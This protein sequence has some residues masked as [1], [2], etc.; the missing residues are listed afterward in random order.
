MKRKLVLLL[1]LTFVLPFPASAQLIMLLTKDNVYS[2]Y[3]WFSKR[4]FPAEEVTAHWNEGR[5]IYSMEYTSCGTT[6]AMAKGTGYGYQ[7]YKVSEPF[8]WPEEWVREQLNNKEHNMAISDVAYDARWMVVCTEGT[9]YINQQVH[10]FEDEYSLKKWLAGAQKSDRFITSIC[11]GNHKWRVVSSQ[12][13]PYRSQGVFEAFS[14][15]GVMSAINTKVWDQGLYVHRISYGDGRYMVV[16]GADKS[17]ARHGQKV[18]IEESNLYG[19]E[20]IEKE[21]RD[22]YHIVSLGN[23]SLQRRKSPES[24]K[25]SGGYSPVIGQFQ[26]TPDAVPAQSPV[27]YPAYTPTASPTAYPV[28]TPSAPSSTPKQHGMRECP[29]CGGKGYVYDSKEYGPRYTAESEKV[30]CDI[31]HGYDD[32]HYHK[33]PRCQVCN[34]KGKVVNPYD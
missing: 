8:K 2:D 26:Y 4:G 12:G 18:R 1:A 22:G 20:V 21:L 15:S 5:R 6:V 17:N 25:Q 9:G 27:D 23:H 19:R 34:G 11:F 24:G 7:T 32:R 14:Y 31:C 13:T 29:G 3:V 28:T 16:Y 30:W 10:E 33:R